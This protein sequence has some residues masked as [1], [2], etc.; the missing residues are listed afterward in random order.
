MNETQSRPDRLM[1]VFTDIHFWVPVIVLVAGLL[2]L[3]LF[4]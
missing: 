3:R 4:H 1:P 2:V